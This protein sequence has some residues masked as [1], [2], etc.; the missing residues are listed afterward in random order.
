MC[1]TNEKVLA[2]PLTDGTIVLVQA[3]DLYPNLQAS[4]RSG[5][6]VAMLWPMHGGDN[7]RSTTENPRVHGIIAKESMKYKWPFWVIYD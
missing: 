1:L 4:S 5:Y 7:I 6:M 3:M 2:T